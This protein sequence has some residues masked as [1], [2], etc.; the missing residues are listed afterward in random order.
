MWVAEYFN[1]WLNTYGLVQYHTCKVFGTSRRIF[2]AEG[3]SNINKKINYR[4][5]L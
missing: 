2:Y 5:R 1:S 3:Y 4:T